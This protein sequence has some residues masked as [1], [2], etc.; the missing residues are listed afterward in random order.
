MLQEDIAQLGLVE[1][2]NIRSP[3]V[4]LL[5]KFDVTHDYNYVII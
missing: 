2:R 3:I 4:P 1:I 5:S